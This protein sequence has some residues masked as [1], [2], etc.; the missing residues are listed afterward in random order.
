MRP[1][2]VF[3]IVNKW[4]TSPCRTD[5]LEKES[6]AIRHGKSSVQCVLNIAMTD[7]DIKASIFMDDNGQ[8]IVQ[9]KYDFIMY[10]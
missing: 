1:K 2:Y 6:S 5:E 4:M 8:T 9:V 10:S 3:G 7:V